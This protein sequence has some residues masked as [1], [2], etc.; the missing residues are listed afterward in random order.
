MFCIAVQLMATK[1]SAFLYAR[2]EKQALVEPLI[3]SWGWQSDTPG[4]SRF[5]D[6]QEWTGTRDP[7]AYLATPAAIEFQ[8]QNRWD[9][10]RAA[11]H[12]LAV[13]T[14]GRLTALTGLPPLS[15][16]DWF[17]QMFAV[18]LPPCDLD[19]LKRRLYEEFGVEVPLV[20]WNGRQL[21]RVSVQGYNTRRD[22]DRLVTA[23]DR[24]LPEVRS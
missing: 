9:E 19:A 20:R 21:L 15:S 7:A 4:P 3:V 18:P 17:A 23:L 24:L 2:P 8:R 1:G 11:C 16:P 5:V 22:M 13:E 14:Q 10:V 6:E 12:A